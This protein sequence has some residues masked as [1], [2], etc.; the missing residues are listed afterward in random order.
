MPRKDQ[1]SR[2]LRAPKVTAKS[3]TAVASVEQ[4]KPSTRAEDRA[5]PPA[6]S[7]RS[8]YAL[9]APALALIATINTL[10]NDFASDDLAQVLN[11]EFIKD[12]S[13]VPLAFTG[14]VWSFM[15]DIIFSV[16]LYYRPIFNLLLTINY[17]VFGP[18]AWG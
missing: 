2:N 15:T 17:A 1:A 8:W 7:W 18:A 5:T 16:D 6:A 13:N 3:A 12:F 10:W 9:I 4:S 14:S 11:N